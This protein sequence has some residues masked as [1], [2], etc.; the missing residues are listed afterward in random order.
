MTRS[1]PFTK[2]LVANRGEIA[3]RVLTSA[4]KSG[5]ATVAVYSQAD[6]NAAHVMLADQS[7]CIGGA[8]P[9]ESYLRIDRIIEAAQQTGADAIHPGYGFLAENPDLPAACAAAGIV[10]VGP[11]ADSIIKMGDKAG[12]KSL[13]IAAGV[14][15]VP[16]YQGDD[17][18]LET[19]SAEADKIGYPLMIKATAGGGGRGMRLVEKAGDFAN[20]LTAAKSEAKAGFGNDIVLLERAIINPRHVEIQIMAD[21]HGNVIHCGERDCSVQ[22]RHQKLIEESPSPAVDL[23][24]RARMGK[25]SIDAV[26]AIGY[27]GAGTFEYLLD[28]NGDFYFMEMN[29]RLQVEHPVTEAITGLDLVALQLRI[30]SGAP[31][32]IAQ[33]DVSFS[34]HAIEIRLCAEDPAND[35]MPQ[36]GHMVKWHPAGALRVDHGL[37]NGADIPP[38]YDSM[39][40]KIIAYGDSRE[41]ARRKLIAGTN[42]TIA[43]GVR[44]NQSFLVA[45]LKHPTFAKGDATTGFIEQNRDDLLPDQQ[46][47]E[48]RAAMIIAGLLRAAPSTALTHGF[49][50]PV[51]LA[52]NTE[53]HSVRV[54]AGAHGLCEITC[55]DTEMSLTVLSDTAGHYRFSEGGRTSNAWLIRRGNM[56]YAHIDGTQWDFADNSF[57]SKMSADT[58]GSDGKV[59]ATMNGGVLAV[60]VAIGDSVTAGQKLLAIEAMKMEHAHTAAVDGIISAIHVAVGSQ[61]TAH[62]IV[63]EVEPATP[64]GDDK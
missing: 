24:L 30:A 19:L 17:Q 3:V 57:T 31:L 48:Q 12:A 8:A 36:S 55:G 25:A 64:A 11:S 5:Y 47:N 39:V 26:L 49:G 56:I 15:C 41:E 43:L 37:T 32:G 10:F 23:E 22:R 21:R 6:A 20:H 61:V 63:V 44:T 50:A 35:F 29:T 38:F 34:G 2:L 14:P 51:R 52:R 60:D 9:A 1:T 59:R 62:S 54:V 7:V 28:E 42:D 18:S 58:A 53:E 16:G 40:A 45:C 4:K 27:E 13:M 46:H 33:N